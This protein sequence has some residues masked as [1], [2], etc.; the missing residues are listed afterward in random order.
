[1]YK[2][3]RHPLQGRV[4]HHRRRPCERVRRAESRTRT[5]DLLITNE[6][7]YQLSYFGVSLDDAKVQQTFDTTK[8]LRFGFAFATHF[9]KEKL[10]NTDN[11]VDKTE[12][13][14]ILIGKLPKSSFFANNYSTSHCDLLLDNFSTTIVFEVVLFGYLVGKL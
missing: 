11:S 1:M 14:K 9:T 7:L 2:K 4:D 8:R 12:I 6:L 5:G 3:K 13:P 10:S